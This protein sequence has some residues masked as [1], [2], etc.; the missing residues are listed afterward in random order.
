MTDAR[1]FPAPT[2]VV[3]VGRLGL[4]VLEQLAE[5]WHRLK[6]SSQDPSIKNLRLL[7]VRPQ[8]DG[9]DPHWRSQERQ[10]VEIA[11]Y[12]GDGDLPSLALDFAIMR[13]LGLIRY[14]DGVYQVAQP[15]D[16]GIVEQAQNRRLARRRYFDWITLHLDPLIAA[17]RLGLLV[18]KDPTLG[19]FVKPIVNRVR[20]GHSP[21]AL[22]RVISRCRALTQGRDPSPWSWFHD[23]L[24]HNVPK[25]N[26]DSLP[27][28]HVLS[29]DRRWI[30]ADDLQ[31]LLEN[32][33]AEPI[34]GWSQWLKGAHHDWV[35]TPDVSRVQL[36]TDNR[37][38]IH[39]P[40]PLL[41]GPRDLPSPLVPFNLLRV[42]WETNGWATEGKNLLN[43]VEFIPVACS[44]YRLG[45]F[46]HDGSSRVQRSN[47]E[48]FCK[49][50]ELLGLHVH[51][52]LVRLWVDLQR[53]RVEDQSFS[54]SDLRRREGVDD[55][56]RQSLEVLGELLVRPLLND[57]APSPP[58]KPSTSP[59]VPSTDQLPLEPSD[60]LIDLELDR[61]GEQN[62]SLNALTERLIELGFGSQESLI[63]RQLLLSQ[64]KL[65][66]DHVLNH[67]R[68]QQRALT[69][70]AH[71]PDDVTNGLLAFRQQLNEQTRQ[72][73][74][75]AYLSSYRQRPSRR[76]AR[77]TIFIVGDA[78]EPFVRASLRSLLRE[79]HAELLRSFAPIF[80]NFREG[81]DRSLNIIPILWMPHPADAFGGNHPEENRCEEA[82][83]IESVHGIRRWVE[84]VPRGTRCIPQIIIN[85]RVTD[86]AVLSLQEAVNQTRDFLSFQLRND[87]SRDAWLRKT[88]V[89]PAGDDFFS[90][91]TCHEV[92]FPAERSREYLANRL[93]RET[94]A[95]I[96]R[97]EHIALPADEPD[98]DLEPPEIAALIKPSTARTRQ[99]TRKAADVTGQL[100]EDRVKPA[101]HVTAEALAESFNEDFERELLKHIYTQW[102]TLTRAR[103]EMDD[104]MNELRRQTSTQLEKTIGLVRKKGDALIDEHASYG[105]LK[106]AQAGFDQLEAQTREHL[107]LTEE[108][109]QRSEDI[110][111]AHRI[112]QTSPIASQREAL[113][114]HIATKPELNPMRFGA[115]LWILMSPALA[116]PVIWGIARGL[117]L[118]QRQNVVEFIFGPLG[119]IIG[120]VLFS[121]PVLWL[122]RRHM[123]TIIEEIQAKI[124][125]LAETARSVVEGTG[126]SFGS[127]PSIRSFIE[128][129][130]QLTASLNTRNYALRVH[131]RVVQ[132]VRLAH[133]LSRSIDIQEDVLSR[134]AEDLG[135]RIQMS[136]AG[137][138]AREDLSNLFASKDGQRLD[139]LVQPQQLSDFYLRHY[140]DEKELRAFVPTFIAN[141]GSFDTWR[142]EA[143]L[144]DTANIMTYTRDKFAEL[145]D[146]PVSELYMFEEEVGQ[147]LL[148]FV[149]KYYSNMGFGAKFMGYEGLDPDG[150][151]VLCD[152]A[153]VIN[154][155][156][157]V[158]F[159][160][161]RRRPGNSLTETLQVIHTEIRPNTAYM[162]SLVQGIRPH[163]V[164]NLM[165]FESY[166]DRIYLPDDRTFPMSGEGPQHQGEVLPIN[167]MTGYDSLRRDINQRVL[168]SLQSAAR[169]QDLVSMERAISGA[170]EDTTTH[171]ALINEPDDNA[172][173]KRTTRHAIVDLTRL[174]PEEDLLDLWLRQ[175]LGGFGG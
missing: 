132:D 100:V 70:G 10:F 150:I 39:L 46:D 127:S 51:R 161:V 158:V 102:R 162:L 20:Q 115:A 123:L 21:R 134:Q 86:N 122:L 42:D 95:Q 38:D 120:G 53:N 116:A 65:S 166:H 98:K 169:S 172:T 8:D 147:S 105:G 96:K 24:K 174:V 141:V 87:I 83:I 16:A 78:A 138:N 110:C 45:L 60:F 91:F 1:H 79:A 71:D 36:P 121:L 168:H 58:A 74:D 153:L 69:A 9:H 81:F 164:R 3:G 155:A 144:S 28:H 131:E 57:P 114:A 34:S 84:T 37:F 165:R 171:T 107:V 103:G 54:L 139:L 22:L 157:S 25:P 11:R 156:L 104:M 80:E 7:Y 140:G 112:P 43:E 143:C 44:M 137:Q 151:N 33:A 2:M 149:S 97:G 30:S 14:R 47:Q 19:L 73:Y 85:S 31:G 32:F 15:R 146:R 13:S 6:M 109:R 106:A 35:S 49:R 118:H 62:L 89:G 99:R 125:Q 52:G 88:V 148:S 66:A 40:T 163:S 93:A 68:Q 17:E 41:P 154:P 128:A 12:T 26:H 113:V 126:S 48:D 18:D 94:I 82:A 129:R 160:Q 92:V 61:R 124:A 50:L 64:V 117:G 59:A 111:R 133:R 145:V 55:T 142:K 90:S 119:P 135:V 77:L 101:P 170:S 76:C 108:Q 167:H 63:K 5:D 29:F 27:T 23:L 67:E 72:L 56:L 136:V 159:D 130:L 4:A 152:T 173:Q 75:F 175:Q